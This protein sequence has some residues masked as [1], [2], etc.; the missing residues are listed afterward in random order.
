MLY[1]LTDWLTAWLGDWLYGTE[2]VRVVP[3]KIKIFSC[4]RTPECSLPSPQ[5][6]AICPY[7]ALDEFIP[8]CKILLFKMRYN[9][10]LPPR[11]TLPQWL[12]FF[13]RMSHQKSLY[14]DNFLAASCKST[15]SK[16]WTC[17]HSLP[18]IT[19][20]NPAGCVDVCLLWVLY[21]VR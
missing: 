17:S 5:E 13:L 9:I 15:H 7:P 6:T 14:S 12:F 18:G 16:V 1:S 2:S 3:Q 4:F 8:C 11:S 19:G 10:I 20:S 21:V